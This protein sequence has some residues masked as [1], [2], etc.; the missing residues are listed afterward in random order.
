M[1]FWMCTTDQFYSRREKKMNLKQISVAFVAVFAIGFAPMAMAGVIPDVDSDRIPE[2]F[3]NCK[4]IANSQ[5]AQDIDSPDCDSQLDTNGD[6][7]GN[8]CDADFDGSGDIQ[9]NDFLDVISFL[10]TTN[11][12]FED[13]DIDCDG[14]V[15]FSDFLLVIA[16]LGLPV[17]P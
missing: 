13:R 3:D 7:F 1:E 10:G 17:G 6:G 9:F 11:A 8:R 16:A 12:G 5:F 14:G 4:A 2:C 15:Q